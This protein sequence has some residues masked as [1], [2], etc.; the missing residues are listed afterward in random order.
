[1]TGTAPGPEAFAPATST[2]KPAPTR[3]TP[4]ANLAGVEGSQPRLASHSQN[5]AN[6]GAGAT[7]QIEL[8]DW[9]ID[10][11]TSQLRRLRSAERSV[12]RFNDAP[13]CAKSAQNRIE[14]TIR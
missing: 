1:M 10:A 9:N 2:R 12:N 7:M 4:S 8:S 3:I 5:M 13:A 11:G 14:P 6:T